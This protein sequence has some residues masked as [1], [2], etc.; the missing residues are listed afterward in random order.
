[1]K[2]AEIPQANVPRATQI[3]GNQNKLLETCDF[4]REHILACRSSYELDVVEGSFKHLCQ[5]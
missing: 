4:M 2:F 5:L 1:M 3:V